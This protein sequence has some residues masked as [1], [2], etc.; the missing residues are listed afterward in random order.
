MGELFYES[1]R[2]TQILQFTV[3]TDVDVNGSQNSESLLLLDNEMLNCIFIVIILSCQRIV[4]THINWGRTNACNGKLIWY[5][6]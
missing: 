2:I 6:I 4:E 3:L 5:Y 1:M